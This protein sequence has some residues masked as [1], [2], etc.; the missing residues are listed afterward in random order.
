MISEILT[1]KSS[2]ILWY[3]HP[4]LS[5]HTV[6]VF[7]MGLCFWQT[8][9]WSFKNTE[10]S[11]FGTAVSKLFLHTY[12]NKNLLNKCIVLYHMI[13]HDHFHW[14]LI[15]RFFSPDFWEGDCSLF[16]LLL[17]ASLVAQLVKNLPAMQET[18][19]WFLGWED[20]LEKGKATH[21]TIM[22]WGIPWTL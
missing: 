14:I 8:D 11:Y 6:H 13:S 3:T 10:S 15:I 20:Q 16:C 18:M 17:R 21:S 9:S 5:H 7:L 4:K 22:A 2:T 19:V 1:C 12:E